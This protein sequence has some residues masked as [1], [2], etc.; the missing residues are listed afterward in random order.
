MSEESVLLDK[1]QG[2]DHAAPGDVLGGWSL[3]KA[4]AFGVHRV[5]RHYS[6]AGYSTSRS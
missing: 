4:S 5:A 6:L 2:V 3:G 1:A